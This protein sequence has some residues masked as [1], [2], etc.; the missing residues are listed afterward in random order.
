[1][2][3]SD[4]SAAYRH[5]TDALERGELEQARRGFE[6]LLERSEDPAIPFML[7]RTFSEQGRTV[8]AIAYT[9]RA[10]RLSPTPDTLR[11]LARLYWMSAQED[12]FEA[13]LLE[14]VAHPEL[15]FVAV[16]LC[17]QSDSFD[18]ALEMLAKMPE[19]MRRVLEFPLSA[20]WIYME[21]GD[22]IRALQC[23]EL[24]YRASVDAPG[25]LEA[26]A[27]ALLM[28]GRYA[29]A[30]ALCSQAARQPAESVHAA[31]LLLV[32]ERLLGAV[33]EE[34]LRS[35]IVPTPLDAPAGFADMATFNEALR[36]DVQAFHCYQ[37]HPVDQSLRGGSQT[38]RN[39]ATCG[40]PTFRA[41]L[42]QC[43]EA[44]R[45]YI[46]SVDAYPGLERG[47]VTPEI[48]KCWGVRLQPGGFHRSH[49][50]PEGFLSAA[51]YLTTPDTVDHEHG[52]IR[53]GVPP[54]RLPRELQPIAQIRPEDGLLVL[55]PSYLW[56][57]TVPTRIEG[58]AALRETLPF[59]VTLAEPAVS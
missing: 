26:Y 10:H 8:D 47:S 35:L 18:L 22:P 46:A 16:E 52:A 38:C 33:N 36:R 24:A 12:A 34:R 50:H 41:Y 14:H 28:N 25:C 17:R 32:A 43:L 19:S 37:R 42:Q 31:A 23:A 51:Y 30:R 9:L 4:L 45:T 13:L 58:Q 1:V 2:T 21:L 15:G 40:L 11:N 56:H 6:Q 49:I 5:A 48:K 54:F 53:F 3:S 39:V 44:A 59:D 57:G 55:F 7:G 20:A 29:D 27:S